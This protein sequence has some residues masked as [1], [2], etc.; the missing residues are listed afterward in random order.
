MGGSF[1][2]S[3]CA[4]RR[5]EPSFLTAEGDDCLFAAIIAFETEESVSQDPAF[6]IG[7]ELFDHI[8]GKWATLGITPGDEGI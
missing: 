8:L 7:V 4:A 3:F 6:E 1:R 5:T 2:L